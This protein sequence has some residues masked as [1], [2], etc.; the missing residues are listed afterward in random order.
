MHQTRAVISIQM[1]KLLP[2]EE[3][4]NGY[5]LAEFQDRAVKR[6][7]W[8][9]EEERRATERRRAGRLKGELGDGLRQRLRAC[10]PLQLK[11]VRR[12]CAKYEKDHRLAPPI[13]DL[14]KRFTLE[15][16]D[17]VEVKNKRFTLEIRRSSK[18]ADR[19]HA[20]GPYVY[21]YWR[22]GRIIR[23]E[24]FGNVKLRGKLPR[25]VWVAFRDLLTSSEIRAR[26]EAHEA[27]LL[28]DSEQG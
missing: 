4:G 23:F 2:V 8:I 5:S 7:R 18:N 1:E 12:L 25:K 26:I 15:I 20:Y 22:D 3:S 6:L 16:L 19:V 11:A 27:R 13:A 21:C 10:N 24:Y 17:S 9:Q 28:A 14:P